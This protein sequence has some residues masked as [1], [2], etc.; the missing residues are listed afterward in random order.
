MYRIVQALNNNVALVKDKYGEQAVVMGL[1]ITYKK[2][3]GDLIV[4]D[5]IEKVFSLKSSESKENFLTLLRDIPLDFITVTYDVIDSLSS[6]YHYPVQEYL[7]VTLTDHIYCSYK[8]ILDNTY[9]KSDIRQLSQE[10]QEEYQMATEALAIFRSKLLADFPDD[11]IGKIALHFINAKSLKVDDKKLKVRT[12]KTILEQVQKILEQY[13]IKRTKTNVNF[14]DRLMVHLTY[15]IEYLDRSRDDN[16][17]LLEMEDQI[18]QTYPKAYQIA[19]EIYRIITTE[20]G[21]DNYRS[22]RFYIALHIQR[23]L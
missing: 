10:Y 23:L 11:E 17:S 20:T 15:F 4:S 19:D 13:D 18:K 16:L 8:A 3:K 7:Y 2:S 1:G 5:K 9:Q 22:E 6:K 21:I 14:H 12:A